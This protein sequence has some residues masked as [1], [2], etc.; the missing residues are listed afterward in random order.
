MVGYP[1]HDFMNKT[2]IFGLIITTLLVMGGCEE[3]KLPIK[4]C[5]EKG[6][7]YINNRCYEPVDEICYKIM[8]YSHINDD[9]FEE[10]EKLNLSEDKKTLFTYL[11][12]N[13]QDS[14]YRV[15]IINHCDVYFPDFVK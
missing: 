8:N 4:E 15:W 10:A 14:A 1:Q 13:E 9:C 3:E 7:N 2:I 5:E 11:C 12:F 6:W